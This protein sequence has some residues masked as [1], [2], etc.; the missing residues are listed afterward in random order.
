MGWIRSGWA[1]PIQV[2]R[3]CRV[4]GPRAGLGCPQQSIRAYPLIRIGSLCLRVASLHVIMRIPR[5][6]PWSLTSLL[7]FQVVVYTCIQQNWFFERTLLACATP[8]TSHGFSWQWF[9][10]A[11]MGRKKIQISRITDE[12]NRQVSL[13]TTLSSCHS[14]N[15]CVSVS[16]CTRR[17]LILLTILLSFSITDKIT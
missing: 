17:I 2:E 5:G 7:L 12:R 9:K 15:D 1:L 4:G 3:P 6:R 13:S 10:I 11:A 14:R 16:E 8:H